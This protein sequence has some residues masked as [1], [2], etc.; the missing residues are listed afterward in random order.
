MTFVRTPATP[1]K[2]F[3]SDLTRF[4]GPPLCSF[5]FTQVRSAEVLASI[6][7]P[8]PISLLFSRVR[9]SNWLEKECSAE[10]QASS[11]QPLQIIRIFVTACSPPWDSG[12]I[13]STEARSWPRPYSLRQTG[14]V[15][16]RPSQSGAKSTSSILLVTPRLL[17]HALTIPSFPDAS[18]H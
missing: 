8:R 3:G 5:G 10:R 9:C 18:I 4:W 14:H 1:R 15:S 13:W 6:R 7:Y 11:L 2:H 12:T 16:P 17:A